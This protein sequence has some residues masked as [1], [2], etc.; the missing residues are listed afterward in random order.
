[1][2]YISSIWIEKKLTALL[3][4]L[5]SI[6]SCPI[7]LMMAMR[8]WMVLEYTTGRYCSHSSREYPVSWMIFICLTM[9]LLPDSPAPEK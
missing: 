8:D 3:E 9:V 7:A 4:S 2:E 5:K 6:L 1:M